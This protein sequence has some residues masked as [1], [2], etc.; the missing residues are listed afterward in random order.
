M[1]ELCEFNSTEKFKS[2]R[3]GRTEV[4]KASC[5]AKDSGDLG[6]KIFLNVNLND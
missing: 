6:R 4:H 3:P 1:N 2:T 5:T